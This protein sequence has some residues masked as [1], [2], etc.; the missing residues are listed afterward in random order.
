MRAHTVRA[1]RV[2]MMTAVSA[3][4]MLVTA[5]AHAGDVETGNTGGAPATAKPNSSIG[6]AALKYEQTKGL[7]TSIETGF[8]GPDFAQV[9]VGIKIDPVTNGGPLYTIDM[10]KGANIEASWGTD[11]KIVLKPMPGIQT[12]GLVTVRHTLTPSIDFKFSGFGLT[13]QFGFD[14]TSIV[15][16]LPGARFAYDSKQQQPFAPWGFTAIDTVLNAPDMARAT[17]FSIQMS[18]LPEF[19]NKNVEGFFGVRA[20]TKPTFSYKTTKIVITGADGEIKDA[21][22]ELTVP[23]VDG[24]YMEVM[25][26]VE[27]EMAVKGSIGIQPFVHLDRILKIALDTDLGIDVFNK[28]YTVPNQLVQFQA[29]I[30]HIPMPNV[31]VPAKGIDVGEVNVGGNAS[32][33]IEIENSGEK[34]A[35]MSFKSSDKQFVVTNETVTVPA[36]GKYE[37]VVKFSPDNANAASSEITVQSSDPDSPTQMFRIGANGA[38]V[39]DDKDDKDDPARSGPKADDGCGCKTAGTSSSLPN[40]A[41]FGLLGLGAVVLFRRRRAA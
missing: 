36:K 28:D 16:K 5:Q 31:H 39:G 9:N 29:A 4:L 18:K 12:D 14:A 11:K 32:K 27:G 10:P 20:S 35:S 15:N 38:D 21:A 26:S 17:L 23:A 1:I 3:G 40:W 13:A 24:D 2:G 37:L 25:T 6:S 30:V 22:G 8:K 7:P 19:V 41:G 34:E 33:T